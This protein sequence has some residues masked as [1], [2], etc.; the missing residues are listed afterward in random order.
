M[1]TVQE[2]KAAACAAIDKHADEIIELAVAI[3]NEPELGFKEFKTAKKVQAA[4][5]KVGFAH[6]DGQAVTGIITEV[7]GRN[8]NAKVA[9]M[10]ELDAVVVPGCPTA[11]PVTNAAHSCGHNAQAA[12]VVGVAWA[13]KESGIMDELDGDVALMH[14]PAEEYVEI[15]YRKSLIDEGKIKLLGGKQEFIR[16]GLMD[17]TDVM[18]MQ[19]TMTSENEGKK[20]LGDA[21]TEKS[22]GFVGRLVKYTGKASHAASPWEGINALKAAQVGMAAI[23]AQRETFRP[24]DTVFVHPIVTKGG[25]LVNVVP[26]DVRIETYVRANNVDAILS[27]AVKVDR[28]FQAGADAIGANVEITKLPGYMCPHCCRELKDLVY[29]NLCDFFGKDKVDYGGAEVCTDAG[30]VESIIPSC[31]MMIGVMKPP[32]LSRVIIVQ[33]NTVKLMAAISAVSMPCFFTALPI[34]VLVTA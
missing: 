4:L 5:D 23:D 24:E 31:H 1:M 8:H 10:G 32:S 17:D 21:G 25:D 30:D 13:L 27:N 3:E 16:L 14:V 18:I 26:S 12:S 11:D 29:D 22:L 6:K 19:H 7:P 34:A 28:S 2:M 20:Y 33:R 9:V 15:E